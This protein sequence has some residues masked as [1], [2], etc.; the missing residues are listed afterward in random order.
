[1]SIDHKALF[2]VAL[3]A[4]ALLITS[5]AVSPT[6]ESVPSAVQRESTE[7]RVV[8][9][10]GDACV[11]S[12]RAKCAKVARLIAGDRNADA[13]LVLGDAQYDAGT[14]REYKT[15]WH[16][17][18]ASLRPMTN[19][20]PGNHDYRTT[21]ASG[22]FRYFGE[23]AGR[24]GRGWHADGMGDWKVIAMNTNCSYVGGC[25]PT[26]RQGKFVAAHLAMVGR[27][28]EL[29]F[30]HHPAFTGGRYAPGTPQ[31]REAFG[32]AY[33]GGAELYL[34]GHDHSYQRYATTN[35]Q[36]NTR[37]NG[38]RQVVVGT[39]GNGLTPNKAQRVRPR[40]EQSDRYGALRLRL[41]PG[42]YTGKFVAANGTVLDKFEGRCH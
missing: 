40:Y 12:T 16:R 10:F 1:M 42:G 27:N 7:S 9:A 30:G 6:A 38:T 32:L 36:G 24:P 14:A 13:V 5:T 22:Y 11:A 20:A 39:G 37:R 21:A 29:V 2:S 23:K 17:H 25:G 19:P 15:Y 33:R 41:R 34:A 35:A 28:C 18:M 26:S 31:G 3:A 8:W 4:A